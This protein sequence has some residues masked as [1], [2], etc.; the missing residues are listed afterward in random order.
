MFLPI[1]YISVLSIILTIHSNSHY[2]ILCVLN[3]FSLGYLLLPLHNET[4]HTQML[5]EDLTSIMGYFP[6][7]IFK[8]QRFY[9]YI[10]LFTGIMNYA[11]SI[12]LHIAL[13]LISVHFYVFVKCLTV[14]EIRTCYL[15]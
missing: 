12:T 2:D 14:L 1:H 6:S 7:R 10:L 13:V 15:S 4:L 11:Q 5:S 8:F 9:F 3:P